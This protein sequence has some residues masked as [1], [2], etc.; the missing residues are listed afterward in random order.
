MTLANRVSH[1]RNFDKIIHNIATKNKC[2]SSLQ[3]VCMALKS[4]MTHHTHTAVTGEG[5]TGNGLA[6]GNAPRED[7][8]R[9]WLKEN[10]TNEMVWPFNMWEQAQFAYT[11]K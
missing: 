6:T 2:K 11:P 4:G 9:K 7:Q 8:W 3:T 10:H 1:R 5:T